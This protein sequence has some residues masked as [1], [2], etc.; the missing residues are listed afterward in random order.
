MPFWDQFWH[1]FPWIEVG[2]VVGLVVPLAR[3]RL[4][5][6]LGVGAAVPPRSW[7]QERASWLWHVLKP[8][9]GSLAASTVIAFVLFMLLRKFV[10]QNPAIKLDETDAFFYGYFADTVVAKLSGRERPMNLPVVDPAGD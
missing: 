9:L 1:L 8:Y 7:W 10:L 4:W 3:A 2:I 6:A 5:P